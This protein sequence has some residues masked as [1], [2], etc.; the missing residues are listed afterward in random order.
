MST[1]LKTQ[2]LLEM[3]RTLGGRNAGS[4][5]LSESDCLMNAEGV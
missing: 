1:A 4:V 3:F 5:T 2:I